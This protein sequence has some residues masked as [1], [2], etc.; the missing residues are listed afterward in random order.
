MCDGIALMFTQFDFRVHS[1]KGNVASIVFTRAQA[2]E[3]IVVE[4]AQLF[5]SGRIR[6]NPIPE[7][8]FDKLLF[9]LSNL[10]LLFIQDWLLST[11]FIL[12]IIE[13]ANVFQVQGF[14]DDLVCVDTARSVGVEHLDIACVI[15]F[16]FNVP[17][18]CK[19][20]VVNFDTPLS[21]AGCVQELIHELFH[22]FGRNPCCSETDCDLTGS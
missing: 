11:F 17:L 7:S 15:G 12:D 22:Y 1:V 9:C 3:L 19:R 18:T 20:R 13:N 21:I 10:R 14:L 6:P 5:S 16:V 8:L 2:V 4:P